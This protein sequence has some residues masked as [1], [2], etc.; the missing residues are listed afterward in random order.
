MSPSSE[1]RASQR[2]LLPRLG[3]LEAVLF[4]F[5]GVMTDGTAILSENGLESV[6]VS[7]RDGLG[8]E[9]LRESGRRLAIFTRESN[10]VASERGAKLGIPVYS[11]IL[12][13]QDA[14]LAWC[15]SENLHPAKVA[16]VGDDVIDLPAMA[17]AGVSVC[18]AD[19][20]PSVIS[21]ADIVLKT[22]G[23]K[24]AVREF[25]DMILESDGSRGIFEG[26]PGGRR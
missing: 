25:A 26:Q 22:G 17:I 8:I 15:D 16:F 4:D 5:D 23:G 18:P 12:N 7:R 6:V 14:V 13:K 2:G 11:H 3:D 19:A 24:G 10:P 9:L 20:H 21:I 1:A